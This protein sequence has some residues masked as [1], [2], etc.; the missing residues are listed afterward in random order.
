M[1]SVEPLSPH[2]RTNCRSLGGG[3]NRARGSCPRYKQFSQPPSLPA[4]LPEQ[5]HRHG[6]SAGAGIPAGQLSSD[7]LVMKSFL[8]RA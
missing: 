4:Q 5:S 8:I 1:R 6:L 2:W 7:S 3:R